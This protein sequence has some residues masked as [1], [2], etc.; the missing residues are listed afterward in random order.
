MKFL[1]QTLWAGAILCLISNFGRSGVYVT[2]NDECTDVDVV[3]CVVDMQGG[4]VVNMTM[5]S[6]PVTPSQPA[7]FVDNWTNPQTGTG[8][9]YNVHELHEEPVMPENLGIAGLPHV[10]VGCSSEYSSSITS[11]EFTYEWRTDQ[12]PEWIE[13]GDSRYY[14]PVS[15]GAHWI[16]LRITDENGC[17]TV[18]HKD[19]T[20]HNVVEDI[21]PN[22]NTTETYPDNYVVL[23]QYVA[24]QAIPW[25]ATITDTWEA[26]VTKGTE[27][28][29]SI[30]LEYLGQAIGF[31][32]A[33]SQT[34]TQSVS[35]SI[36]NQVGPINLSAGQTV[37]VRAF[38]GVNVRSGTFTHWTCPGGISLNQTYVHRHSPF[39]AYTVAVF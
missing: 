37:E 32:A 13:W 21:D 35:N 16:E 33:I 23:T 34:S 26:S 27:T 9:I 25:N 5:L 38:G 2:N 39:G 24:T 22:P 7:Y 36:S 17:D 12:Q 30:D 6:M 15:A 28:S 1:F 14:T 10:T 11:S 8:T 29:A 4:V 3:V 19:I 18:A 20:G 31:E